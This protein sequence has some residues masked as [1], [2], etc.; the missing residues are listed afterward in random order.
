MDRHRPNPTVSD[1]AMRSRLLIDATRLATDL[2][3]RERHPS[4][5]AGLSLDPAAKALARSTDTIE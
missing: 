2:F 3:G 4:G 5:D 1:P